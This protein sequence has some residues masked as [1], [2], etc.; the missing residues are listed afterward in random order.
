MVLAASPFFESLNSDPPANVV[1]V[2]VV[3]HVA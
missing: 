3:S 1:F 2:L